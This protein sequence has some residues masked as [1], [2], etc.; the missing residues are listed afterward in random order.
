[1]E[2]HFLTMDEK[3]NISDDMLHLARLSLSGRVQ[4]IQLYI[5]RM[6]RR[7]RLSLPE[8][9]GKLQELLNQSPTPQSPL[10]GTSGAPLP[11]DLDSRLQLVR[12]EQVIELDNEPILTPAVYSSL[13]QLVLERSNQCRL[14]EA[15]LAPSKSIL[16]VGEPGVGKTLCA[17]WIARELRLPLLILDLSAVMSSFLGRTGN[18]VRNV[19]DYAKNEK[20]VLL[21]DELDAVAKRRDDITEVGE[22]KRLVTVLLQEIDDWPSS[23]LLIAATNHA[24]LLDPAIWRR[25][26]MQIEFQIP[27]EQMV[28]MAV[29]QFFG[30]SCSDPHWLSAL[31]I[32][33][34]GRSYS[35]IQRVILNFRR[36]AL[37]GNGDINEQICG[38]IG[39]HV[40]LLSKH[41]K[42]K[43][44]C[45][46]IGKCGLSQRSV[47]S[48]TGMSR[49]TIRKII[50][51]TSHREEIEHV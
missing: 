33:L 39:K 46:L 13:R 8:L 41:T 21:L 34:Q 42:S 6:V 44:V 31:A 35:D 32:C 51:G 26:D 28:K 3:N 12:H 19:M 45:D 18:N 25:F 11:V 38:F 17:K 49:D 16:F 24:S 23:G 15:G 20:C 47:S 30:D 40:R 1:M 48:I 27:D 37:L 7:Y 29:C 2:N 10:R 9:A 14:E 4:D 43:V 5:R 50:G 36:M 22:L